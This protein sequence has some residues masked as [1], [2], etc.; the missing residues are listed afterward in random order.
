MSEE[1][2]QYL[3]GAVV[4]FTT[5]PGLKKLFIH[6]NTCVPSSGSIERFFSRAKLVMVPG[7]S[8]LT[9]Q[10]FERLVLLEAN[11]EILNNYLR[12]VKG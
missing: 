2:D 1:L 6:F 3:A 10:N 7:R 4:D 12:K 9:D 8:R 5:S 11:C